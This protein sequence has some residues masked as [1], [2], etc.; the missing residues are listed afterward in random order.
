MEPTYLVPVPWYCIYLQSR[1]MYDFYLY[2]T[3]ACYH[4]HTVLY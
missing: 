3:D 2:V 1:M 4:Q